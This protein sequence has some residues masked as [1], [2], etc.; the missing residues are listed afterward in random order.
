MTT[1]IRISGKAYRKRKAYESRLK[2]WQ[3]LTWFTVVMVTAWILYAL[4]YNLT[5]NY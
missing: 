4:Q 1:I 5:V 2:H 3:A